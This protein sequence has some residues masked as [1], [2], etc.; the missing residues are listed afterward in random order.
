MSMFCC[1]TLH[2]VN[3]FCLFVCYCQGK[4]HY[5]IDEEILIEKFNGSSPKAKIDQYNFQIRR[6]IQN[7]LEILPTSWSSQSRTNP[8]DAT[9]QN[10]TLCRPQSCLEKLNNVI[11]ISEFPITKDNCQLKPSRNKNSTTKKSGVRIHRDQYICLT[12]LNDALTHQLHLQLI[13]AQD[14]ET[15]IAVDDELNEKRFLIMLRSLN[16]NTH[17]KP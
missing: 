2:W 4:C 11:P 5:G 9:C 14:L 3:V 15:T 12:K 7:Y 13:V 6:R 1:F 8:T 17:I 16:R 10:W